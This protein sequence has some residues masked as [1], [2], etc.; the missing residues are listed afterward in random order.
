MREENVLPRAHV[1]LCERQIVRDGVLHHLMGADGLV[2]GSSRQNELAVG[3]R[4]P[5]D[6]SALHPAAV[7]GAGTKREDDVRL[8]EPLPK[9]AHFLARQHREQVDALT[10]QR[11]DRARQELRLVPGV[12][13]REEQQLALGD[14]VALHDRPLFAEPASR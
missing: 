8:N 7:S 14:A 13:V 9:G 2:S 1:G 5:I 12:G 10:L 11:P 4:V 3:A 6:P